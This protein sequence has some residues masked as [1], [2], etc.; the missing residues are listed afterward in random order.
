MPNDKED[1]LPV[2]EVTTPG[3]KTF[4]TV[5]SDTKLI[6]FSVLG[7]C[8]TQ[9]VI[10]IPVFRASTK[11]GNFWQILQEFEIHHDMQI[12]SYFAEERQE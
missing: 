12:S 11:G 10:K 7:V 3:W 9:Q 5:N 4:H 1:L 6:N 2:R 8:K